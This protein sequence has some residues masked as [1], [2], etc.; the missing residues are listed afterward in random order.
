MAQVTFQNKDKTLPTSDP[1][2][3]IRE[4]DVNE[5]KARINTNDPSKED[6]LFVENEEMAGTMNGVN[7]IFTIANTPV[8]GSLK[9]YDAIRLREGTDWTRVGTTVTFVT[10]PTNRPIADYR[11]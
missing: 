2:R 1:R 10:P 4:E 7:L 5:L 3:L 8:A 11:K 9:I 6:G